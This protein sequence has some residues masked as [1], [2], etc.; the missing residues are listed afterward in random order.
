MFRNFQ[1]VAV[2]VTDTAL[3]LYQSVVAMHAQLQS[4][5]PLF[6]LFTL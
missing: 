3:I 2:S 5:E 6:F 1:R 4:G